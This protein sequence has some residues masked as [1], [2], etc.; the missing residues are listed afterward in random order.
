MLKLIGYL[1]LGYP[2]IEHSMER[3]S[4]YLEAGIDFV[5]VDLPTRNAFLD[6]D[7]IRAR[8]N[9]ALDACSDYAFY[10]DT[11]KK[12]QKIIGE[13][14]IILSYKHTI[15]E[16]G[17]EKFVLWMKELK[18]PPLILVGE[19]EDPLADELMKAGLAIAS[20][21][22]FHL[23]EDSVLNAEKAN[24]FIYMQAKSEGRTHSQAKTL[25]QCISFLKDRGICRPIY[26][27]VGISNRDDILTVQNSGGEAAFIGS[28]LLKKET[29]EEI[30]DYITLLRG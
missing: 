25:D 23:P 14:L 13:K 16:I 9:D 17:I 12:I 8:M 5:E 6:N 4:Y 19:T 20:W 26:C 1:S 22:P 30:V 28:A 24:G 10:F 3:L 2:T 21:I 27:G 15:R 18:S 29:R 7:F 11:M